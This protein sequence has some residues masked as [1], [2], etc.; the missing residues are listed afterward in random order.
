MKGRATQEQTSSE[1]TFIRKAREI[2]EKKNG[3]SPEQLYAERK[4]RLM[5]AVE[6]RVPDRVP[7]PPAEPVSRKTIR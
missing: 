4:K 5:D 7:T 1:K 3:K 2:I 6:L